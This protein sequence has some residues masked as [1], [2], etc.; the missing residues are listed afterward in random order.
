MQ[1]ILKIFFLTTAIILLS[2]CNENQT[3]DPAPPK[4]KSL[5]NTVVK[6]DPP[7][8][9][10]LIKEPPYKYCQKHIS[11]MNYASHYIS[12]EFEDGYFISNDIE[13]AKAQL[14]LIESNSPTLYAENINAALKSYATQYNLAKKYKCD[15]A[16]FIDTPLLN[17]KNRI[18]NLEKEKKATK[19]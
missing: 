17:I 16:N 12:K 9:T 11:K 7:S 19:K 4:N 10:P 3:N 13:G 14:F 8:K 5:Q 15:I 18:E 2:G 6:N 1:I